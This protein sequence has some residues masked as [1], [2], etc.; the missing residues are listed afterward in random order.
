MQELI[1]EAKKERGCW[2]IANCESP[3]L[4]YET[5]IDLSVSV[6]RSFLQYDKSSLRIPAIPGKGL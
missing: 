2:K 6:I 3:F 4:F 1:L 5:L